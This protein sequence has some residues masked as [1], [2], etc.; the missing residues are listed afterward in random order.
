M[1]AL[2]AVTIGV[3]ARWNRALIPMEGEGKAIIRPTDL[4][5]SGDCCGQ[6]QHL[7]RGS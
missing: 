4:D 2:A 3:L 1:K 7:P 6:A 5:A